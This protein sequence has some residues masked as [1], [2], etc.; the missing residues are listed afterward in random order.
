DTN[1]AVR[2]QACAVLVNV[3]PLQHPVKA[4]GKSLVDQFHALRELLGDAH[5][6]VRAV[7][8]RG[9]CRILTEFWEAIP[10][11]TTLLIEMVKRLAFDAS[12]ADVRL[13]V[14]EGMHALLGCPH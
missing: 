11:T 12:S 7:A 5:A 10:S 2:K 3:F 6:E 8:V 13:A 9:V 14:V 1:P 4:A